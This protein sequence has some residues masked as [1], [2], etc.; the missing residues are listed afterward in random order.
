MQ[1]KGFFALAL[2]EAWSAQNRGGI[3]KDQIIAIVD[4][5]LLELN[6]KVGNAKR[7]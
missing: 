4:A 2:G 1:A 6:Q 7:D 3:W 5:M